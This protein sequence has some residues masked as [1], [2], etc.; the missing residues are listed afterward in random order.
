MK[1]WIYVGL[2][3]IGIAV[4]FVL[5]LY[6]PQVLP[7]IAFPAIGLLAMWAISKQPWLVGIVVMLAPI[8]VTL[9]CPT[10]RQLVCER[11]R[12][13]PKL[14]N[15]YVEMNTLIGF[16]NDRQT[17]TDI[18]QGQV[19]KVDRT[20]HW[21]RAPGD[22]KVRN[23]STPKSFPLF[24]AFLVDRS[25]QT[26]RIERVVP[27]QSITKN[28]IQQVNQ[29]FQ[30]TASRLRVD[31]MDIAWMP[32]EDGGGSKL[33]SR[34]EH[35]SGSLFFVPVYLVFGFL[36]TVVLAAKSLKGEEG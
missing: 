26:H 24:P 8:L 17:F 27:Y 36:L 18:Q 14:A 3:I 33:S 1:R 25:G 11:N 32:N 4:A 5:H 29:F 15:C 16:R 22:S 28:V 9:D 12:L 30:G 13:Q 2:G 23:H 10:E 35:L 19:I 34:N 21:Y 7:A 31:L 6:L 20:T